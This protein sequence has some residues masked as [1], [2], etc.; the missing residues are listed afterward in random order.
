MNLEKFLTI[1]LNKLKDRKIPYCILRNYEGLPRYNLSNDIDILIR[2]T[3]KFVAIKELLSIGGI[4][5]TECCEREYVTSLF[6]FGITWGE[7]Y[8]AIQLDLST[9]LNWKGLSY[10]NVE[11][12]IKEAKP[13]RSSIDIII[14]P[15]SPHEAIISLFSSYLVGGWI[16]KKY[17]PKIRKIFIEYREEITFLL[18][19]IAKYDIVARLVDS[20]CTDNDDSLFRILPKIR[21]SIFLSSIFKQPL[22]TFKSVFRYYVKELLIR[23][24]PMY[25]KEVC[26]LGPDGAGK[27]SVIAGAKKKLLHITKFIQIQHLKPQVFRITISR[28]YTVNPHG[29]QPRSALISILKIIIW[30]F[31]YW[32]KKVFH[33]QKSSTLIFWDRYFYDLLVDPKRYRYGGPMGA[34]HFLS[35][36][37]PM[38]NL[39]ILL[40]AP[41]EVLQSRKKEVSYSEAGRQ[42][43]AYLNLVGSMKNGVVIDAS[44][45]LTRVIQAT[46]EAIIGTMSLRV[47]KRS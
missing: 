40:D 28:K 7:N 5:I 36:I 23:Y 38:P 44:Q 21:S 9:A 30:S 33:G 37:V 4:K 26:V 3:D 35:R 27:S 12:V 1:Y 20:V 47:K 25:I 15:Y 22:L 31:E 42:R 29:A 14:A 13:L 2:S 39:V 24:T 32:I 16:K 43:Q 8:N 6:I 19:Q 41:A 34:V 11:K 10:L 17:Q 18:S 46:C 45:S